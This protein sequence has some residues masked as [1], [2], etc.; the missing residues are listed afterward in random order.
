MRSCKG[1]HVE[2]VHFT[3]K[4]TDNLKIQVL[5]PE[6]FIVTRKRCFFLAEENKLCNHRTFS[7]FTLNRRRTF[8]NSLSTYL[9]TPTARRVKQKP[10]KH[11]PELNA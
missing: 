1:E 7:C 4:G 2:A 5:S 9:S 6:V 10:L 11:Q 8:L 3:V